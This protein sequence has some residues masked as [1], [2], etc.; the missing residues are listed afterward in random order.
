MAYSAEGYIF[1]NTN[2]EYITAQIVWS[3]VG[4]IATNTS[5][6][7]ASLQYKRTNTGHTTYG[8]GTFS[9]YIDGAKYTATKQIT[10]TENA[11]VTAITATRKVSHETNGTKTITFSVEGSIPGTTLTSTKV[12][13]SYDLYTLPKETSIDSLTCATS[14]FTGK[15]TYRYTP[16][17]SLVYN[18]CNI[19][20]NKDGTYIAVKSI[21]LGK[22]SASQQTSTVT[23]S[24]SE[25]ETIYKE[26]PHAKLGKLRF[27]LRTYSDSGYNNQVGNT[28][29]KEIH[30]SIPENTDTQPTTTM[31]L[32]PVSSLSAPFSSL[33]IQGKTK[34]D[35]NFTNSEAKY[36]SNIT[37]HTLIVGGKAYGSPY[38][39]GYLTTTGDITVTGS[40]SDSRGFSRKYNKTITVIPYSK[41]TLLPA[42]GESEIICARCDKD[43]NINYSGTHLKIK[44][45]RSYSKVMSDGAQNNYCSIRY[46]YREE[47]ASTFSDWKTI[48]SKTSD[49]DTIDSSPIANVVSS[50]DTAYVVQVGVIDDIGE[51]DAVQFIVPTDFTTI[52]IPE[53]HN[54][55]RIGLLRYAKDTDEPGI[56]VGAPIHGGSVDNLTLGEMITATST[57][58]IDLNDFRTPSCYYSPDA[59]N[60]KYIANTPYTGGGFGLEVREMQSA[61][62]IRQ[63]LYYG[64]TRWTRHWNNAEWSGWVR[65]LMTSEE[66]SFASDFVTD[67]G[68]EN[69]WYYKKW[70]SGIFD[71]FGI[72]N[73]TVTEASKEQGVMYYSEQFK[74]PTPF[75][76]KNATV[77]GTATNWFIPITGGVSNGDDG[78]DP[79]KNVGFRVYRPTAFA[80]GE[81]FSVRLHVSGELG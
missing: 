14:F 72:F 13:E 57:A 59:E 34:V 7:T 49:T 48:L 33:Y 61:N 5:T 38:T 9:I 6:I 50:T 16:K 29:Y 60:S 63:E 24:E 20:L 2:N 15:M 31:T 32:S 25:L 22:K 65:F 79:Y 52:D 35:A 66:E 43:G 4:D 73:I 75:T 27:T 44:A 42:S 51:S 54:G 76:M 12:T 81:T 80:S 36:G 40:V 46:R 55:K 11:W 3:A 8:T 71:M 67:S 74:L 56:D 69:G 1:G 47:S 78:E 19:S 70:K 62:Y 68:N 26:I 64:R 53:A 18:R 41:P 23:L 21:N 45:K 17:S 58:P 37:T 28:S 77:S 30:L 39:S 10:I